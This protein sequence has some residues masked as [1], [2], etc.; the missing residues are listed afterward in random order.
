MWHIQSD[1]NELSLSGKPGGQSPSNR[2]CR[3]LSPKEASM[4]KKGMRGNYTRLDYIASMI[5]WQVSDDE[6]E[7]IW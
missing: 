2:K 6:L 3:G 4:L 1:A 5:W 7:R